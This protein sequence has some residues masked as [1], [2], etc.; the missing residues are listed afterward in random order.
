[1]HINNTIKISHISLKLEKKNEEHTIYYIYFIT[2]FVQSL[3]ENSITYMGHL[4]R[5]IKHKH[6]DPALKYTHIYCI[7]KIV[8]DDCQ[9][10]NIRVNRV[11]V[12]LTS[13]LFP[14]ESCGGWEMGGFYDEILSVKNPVQIQND[15][16][17]HEL[18]L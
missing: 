6:Q 14:G 16:I 17:F 2:L 9:Q 10:V 8:D 1:M 15:D 7:W 4:T 5:V 11:C 12:H 13:C 3:L 18:G